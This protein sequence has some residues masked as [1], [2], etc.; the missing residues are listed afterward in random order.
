M[1]KAIQNRQAWLSHPIFFVVVEKVKGKHDEG[2]G[3]SSQRCVTH[4][5]CA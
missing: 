4:C 5:G 2:S 3:S 1:Y